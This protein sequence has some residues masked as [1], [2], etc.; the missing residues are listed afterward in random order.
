MQ[1]FGIIFHQGANQ[2]SEAE[3]KQ[4]ATETRSWAQSQNA[5]GHQLEPRILTPQRH[6][7]YPDGRD[8]TEAANEAGAITALLFLQAADLAQAVE[9]ARAHPAVRYGSSIE[10]RAWAPPVVPT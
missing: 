4:R 6:S 8:S 5:A 9:V 2:L 1:T 3:L 7:I 10:V